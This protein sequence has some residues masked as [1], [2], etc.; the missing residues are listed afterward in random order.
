MFLLTKKKLFY[1]PTTKSVDNFSPNGEM[2]SQGLY[3]TAGGV[4]KKN[5]LPTPACM[6]HYPPMLSHTGCD[7]NVV[8][9][10]QAKAVGIVPPDYMNCPPC[11]VTNP[12]CVTCV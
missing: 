11:V 1:R 9:W 8:T 5:N 2:M 6:Q 12:P 10:Q 7:S 3:I 4:S